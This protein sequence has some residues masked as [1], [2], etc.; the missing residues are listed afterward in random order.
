MSSFETTI[1]LPASPEVAWAFVVERGKEVEPLRFEPQGAQAVDTL[2]HLSGR[3]FGVIPLRGVSR[4]TAW[5]PPTTC[6]FESIKPSWPFRARITETFIPANG[7]T[8]HS[9]HYDITP[10]G[11]LGRLIEPLFCHL[12]KRSRRLYQ[13]R[14]RDALARSA[15]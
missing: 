15:T 9:I 5:N 2:N 1:E 11:W 3:L 10:S 7:C 12:M 8:Q 4:T 6:A 13:E 14:L